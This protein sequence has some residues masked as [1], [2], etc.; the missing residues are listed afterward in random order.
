MTTTEFLVHSSEA[1]GRKAGGF[2]SK[3]LNGWCV[4]ALF[5]GA[6]V[7]SALSSLYTYEQY[8]VNVKQTIHAPQD[9]TKLNNTHLVLPAHK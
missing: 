6:L 4:G 5:A 9:P 7:F 3:R 8:T 1:A 2:W